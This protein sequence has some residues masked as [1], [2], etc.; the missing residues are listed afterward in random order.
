[1]ATPV[2]TECLMVISQ[3]LEV[4]YETL[5]HGF[6]Y[7]SRKMGQN[8]INSPLKYDEAIALQNSFA[9]NLY[10]K[11]FIFIVGKLN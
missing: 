6:Q 11:I 2:N 7:K 9:K 3:L 4:S 10:E 5:S 8:I 1:M